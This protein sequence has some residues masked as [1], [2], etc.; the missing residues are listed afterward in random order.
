MK[1]IGTLKFKF[2]SEWNILW[3]D[4]SNAFIERWSI[5]NNRIPTWILKFTNQTKHTRCDLLKN[6]FEKVRCTQ[7][8]LTRR[9]RE[10]VFLNSPAIKENLGKFCNMPKMTEN[11]VELFNF[12]KSCKKAWQGNALLIEANVCKKMYIIFMKLLQKGMTRRWCT[13]KS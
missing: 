4:I 11:F 5:K 10:F 9:S 1:A 8:Y 3:S 2:R 6:R 12:L 7:I 13:N